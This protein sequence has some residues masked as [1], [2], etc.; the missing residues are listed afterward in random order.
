MNRSIG[1][2]ALAAV[3]ATTPI[4]GGCSIPSREMA[5]PRALTT[6]AEIPGIPNARLWPGNPASIRARIE[7][8]DAS[9]EATR[10]AGIVP[11]AEGELAP[12]S[13]DE[14]A[15]GAGVP[16]GWTRA[17]T[18]PEFKPATGVSTGALTALF[19]FLDLDYD[20]E[21]KTVYTTISAED[22]DEERGVGDLY[23]M[24]LE[25]R[26]DGVDCNLAFIGP[27]FDLSSTGEFDTKYVN[28]RFNYGYRL[29]WKSHPWKKRPPGFAQTL[30]AAR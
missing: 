4:V 20:D 5:V 26:R 28:A 19:A 30:P 9:I 22:I 23:R 18:R 27:E 2:S 7:T 24:Y 13:Y 29:D 16:V 21:L 17:G 12:A 8:A 14:G 1:N 11:D 6:E 10:A 15:F 3:V 25:A